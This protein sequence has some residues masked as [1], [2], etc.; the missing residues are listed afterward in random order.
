MPALSPRL[1]DATWAIFPFPSWRLTFDQEI[2]DIG[3]PP[4][5]SDWRFTVGAIIAG[6]ANIQIAAGKLLLSGGGAQAGATHLRYRGPPPSVLG[7]TTAGIIA[8]DQRLPYP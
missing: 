4:D 5:A 3:L 2:T 7:T 8:F 6:A 1:T